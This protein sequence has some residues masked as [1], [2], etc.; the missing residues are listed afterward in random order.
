MGR[1]ACKQIEIDTEI[2]QFA[3]VTMDEAAARMAAGALTTFVGAVVFQPLD[4]V[5]TRSQFRHAFPTQCVIASVLP[6]KPD[7]DAPPAMR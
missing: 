4:Y 7:S 5:K 2:R 1:V 6:Q 3:D